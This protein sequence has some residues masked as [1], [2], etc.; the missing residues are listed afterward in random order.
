MYQCV[1]KYVVFD[2]FPCDII[3]VRGTENSLMLPEPD[4]L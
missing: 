3:F 4:R 1:Q 2:T